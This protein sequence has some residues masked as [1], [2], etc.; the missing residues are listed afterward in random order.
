MSFE[1]RGLSLRKVFLNR[2]S[3]RNWEIVR[4]RT[5]RVSAREI[6]G[7]FN[8]SSETVYDVLRHLAPELSKLPPRP[9]ADLCIN[10]HALV[11]NPDNVYWF[12]NKKGLYRYR[13]KVCI[14]E[15]VRRSRAKMKEESK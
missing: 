13:C 5:E 4:L 7:I 6:A 8:I 9:V 2:D 3:A 10:G 14:R 12:K 15:S 1:P 11:D